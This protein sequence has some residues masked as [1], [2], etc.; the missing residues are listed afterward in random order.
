M[1][2]HAWVAKNYIGGKPQHLGSFG[3]YEDDMQNQVAAAKAWDEAATLN[4]WSDLN[5]TSKKMQAARRKAVS[6]HLKQVEE[7]RQLPGTNGCKQRKARAPKMKP[8]HAMGVGTG[9]LKSRRNTLQSLMAGIATPVQWSTYLTRRLNP[10]QFPL[11]TITRH[12]TY[13]S[14][15]WQEFPRASGPGKNR[16]STR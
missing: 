1:T 4:S 14:L 8:R 6:A 7:L 16:W 5:F 9:H 3:Q 2:W 10:T 12:M 11:L 15:D 13:R